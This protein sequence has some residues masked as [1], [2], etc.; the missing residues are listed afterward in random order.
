VIEETPTSK[1]NPTL[2]VPELYQCVHCGLCLDACPT[3]RALHIESESPR[4][5]IHLVRAAAEGRV[6]LNKIFAGHLNLCLMCRACETAC[7]S[8]VKYG[9]IAEAAREALG[10]PGSPLARATE[11]FAFTRVLP[12][13]SRLRMLAGLLRHYQQSGLDRLMRKLLP[14]RL[15]EMSAMLPVVPRRFFRPSELAP[16]LGKTR[17][18]VGMLGGCVMSVLFPDINEATLGVLQLNGCEVAIPQ[19]QVCCGALNVH[20]GETTAAKAMARRNIDA[21]LA[22]DLDAIIVNA[23]GCGAAMKEYGHLLRDDPAY[24]EKAERFSRRVKDASEFLVA[25][26]PIAPRGRIDMTVTYQDPCHLAHGQKVR[27]QPRELLKII[28]GLKFTE[29]NAAD[30]CCGS[31]GIYNLTHPEMSQELL[32]EKMASIAATGAEAVVAPNPGC[33]LQLRYGAKRYG[34]PV[35]VFHLIE[36]LHRAYGVGDEPSSR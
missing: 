7:P 27:A 5:R 19:D 15:R 23:A 16:A 35:K 4:G 34:P 17:A 3:Y 13:P 6:E 36:L 12:Y 20:N 2:D 24:A 14:Q 28:P 30:R 1:S 10:P 18:R 21:F 26:G 29:M 22:L 25:L 11:N 33:M 9:R 31:A 8:G 32:K